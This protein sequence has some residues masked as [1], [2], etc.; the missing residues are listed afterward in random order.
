MHVILQPRELGLLA[1]RDRRTQHL[2][3]VSASDQGRPTVPER[4]CIALCC[5]LW[6]GLWHQ[7]RPDLLRVQCFVYHIRHRAFRAHLQSGCLN[8]RLGRYGA[9]RDRC[10]R[11]LVLWQLGARQGLR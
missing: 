4:S 11:H 10:V 8:S 1:R 9:D 5:A 7:H 2:G 6:M 3:I